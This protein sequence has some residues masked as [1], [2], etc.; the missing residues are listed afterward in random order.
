MKKMMDYLYQHWAYQCLPLAIYLSILILSS[1]DQISF[2]SALI[3]LQFPCYLIHEFEEHAY[4]G[5]FKAFVNRVI[6]KV[7]APYEVLTSRSVFW[8]N[9]PAIWLLFP[10]AA[11]LAQHINPSIGAILPIFALFNASLHIIIFCIKR[12]YNPGLIVSFFINYPTG[13]YT[14][15]MM[16]QA[17]LLDAITCVSAFLLT[18]IVHLAIVFYAINRYKA[19]QRH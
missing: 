6:F 19:L 7:K 3:W 11:I 17:A 18:L 16:D 13:I 5:G 15:Y 1:I 8:I 14:L 12:R 4:P 2:I 10:T 9:I